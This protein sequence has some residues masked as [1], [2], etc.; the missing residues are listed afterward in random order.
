MSV[1]ASLGG[2]S[3]QLRGSIY[4][5]VWIAVVAVIDKVLN[6]ADGSVPTIG[7][8]LA[9]VRTRSARR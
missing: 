8:P 4:K 2:P 5:D 6:T 9:A 7:I 1:G 3:F